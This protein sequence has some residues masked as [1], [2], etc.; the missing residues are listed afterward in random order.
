MNKD[1]KFEQ[2]AEEKIE[3]SRKIPK[4]MTIKEAAEIFFQGNVSE[5]LIYKLAREHRIP[6]VKL[7]GG[8]ILL[9]TEVLTD[10]WSEEVRKSTVVVGRGLRR[11]D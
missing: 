2:K 7:T 4:T 5:G 1:N 8:K 10:W 6:H 9:D 3:V 11:I